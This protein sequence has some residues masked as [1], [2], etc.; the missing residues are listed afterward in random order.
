MRQRLKVP[1]EWLRDAAKSWSSHKDSRLAAALAFY[2]VFAI[3]PLLIIA[4][5]MAG[6]VFGHDVIRAHVLAQVASLVGRRGAALVHDMMAAASHTGS[7]AL[8]TTIGLLTILLGASGIFGQLQDALNT[9]W[10]VA[11]RK[12]TS[13]RVFVRRR[14]LSFSMVLVLGFLLLVSLILS[15][16][17]G[18]GGAALAG[19]LPD[20]PRLVHA[21]NILLGFAITS[22]LFALVF[23]VLPD[24]RVRWREAW[25]GALA[26]AVL[27][28]VGR[29]LIGLYLWRSAIPSAYGAAG[30]LAV[31]LTWIYFS[32]QIL[33]FGC[34]LTRAHARQS[35]RPVVCK[36][37]VAAV[38][39]DAKGQQGMLKPAA[40]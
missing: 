19:V 36:P 39:A 27:F 38:T 13:W 17:V 32:A 29:T 6:L 1:Y 7:T 14:F 10:E 16:L 20:S 33:L 31:I 23:K 40:V 12:G 21:F 2:T 37:G 18:A 3:A 26:T 22:T 24:V 9:I 25:I 4:T 35:G 28:D 11:P 30:A 8:A 34:E 5:A 15:A